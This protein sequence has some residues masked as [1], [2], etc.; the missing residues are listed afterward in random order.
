MYSI[1]GKDKDF[2]LKT[3]QYGPQRDR[4]KLTKSEITLS[5]ERS[6]GEREGKKKKI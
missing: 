6:S 5:R 1:G 3:E 2:K 4:R